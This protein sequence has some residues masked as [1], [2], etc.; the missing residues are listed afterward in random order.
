M[1]GPTAN[2]TDIHV[3]DPYAWKCVLAVPFNDFND[4]SIYYGIQNYCHSGG[5]PDCINP[6]GGPDLYLT[7]YNTSN[8]GIS[9]QLLWWE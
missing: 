7:P 8:I 4:G 3:A 2:T 1:G 6:Y 9:V 5:R